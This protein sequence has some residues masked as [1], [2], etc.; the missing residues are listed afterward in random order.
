MSNRY[1]I[2]LAAGKGTRM[3]SKLYKVLHK[4]AGK[5]MVEHVLAQVA[6][7]L[8]KEIITVVGHGADA[9]KAQLKERS[10]YVLQEEQL[11][12]GHAVLQTRALLDD[13]NGETLVI[14]GD[15]PLLTAQTLKNLFEHHVKNHASV[16]VLTAKTE[17]P[18]GYGRIIRNDSG[19]IER[20]VEQKDATA[21]E[22]KV[23][24]INTGV[25][26]FN[27][28]LLFNALSQLNTNNA[29]GEYYLT[30]VIE[31]L[32]KHGK[33]VAAFQISSFKEF[34]GVNDRIALA[35]ANSLM[36]ER[37]NHSHMMNSVTLLDPASTYIEADVEIGSDTIIE[38]NVNLKGQTKIGSNVFIGSDSEI[39]D[40]ILEDD[41]RVIRSV[42]EGS[43]L[44]KGADAGP[45]AHLRPK[46]ELG[47]NAHVG[48]FVEVKA[49]TL[50]EGVKAGHLTYVGDAEIGREVN[51]GAGVIFVNYDGKN[52]LKAKIDDYAFIGSNS[53]IVAPI[54]IGKNAVVAAGSTVNQN[55]PEDALALGRARQ[56]VKKGYARR[57]NHYRKSK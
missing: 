36:R 19:E 34:L 7:T 6:Q 53:D 38:G 30:D 43:V 29:H 27:N 44:R 1:A 45:F 32:K 57:Y 3:K 20:I 50:G 17:D 11:G 14:S 31:I 47:K 18:T 24:E 10:S 41:T 54:Y 42:I 23:Q 28:E 52:K 51:L 35:E 15:T 5:S 37:I 13:K 26:I 12:T 56:V 49:A 25:Y 33:K 55:V 22:A 48:N 9:V 40:S 4:V 21:L 46:S 2:I 8:P 16:T 39:V